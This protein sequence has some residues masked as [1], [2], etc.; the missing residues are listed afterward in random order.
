MKSL[1]IPPPS[2]PTSS[3]PCSLINETRIYIHQEV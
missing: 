3:S 2:I 1:K